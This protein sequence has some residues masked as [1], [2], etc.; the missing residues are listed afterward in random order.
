M[1]R[2]E[3]LRMLGLA[4]LSAGALPVILRS[5]DP[6]V[7]DARKASGILGTIAVDRSLQALVGQSYG[8]LVGAVGLHFRDTPYIAGTLEGDRE[9]CRVVLSGVDCVTFFE[10]TIAI[11]NLLETGSEL[12]L[13]VLADVVTKTRYRN[14]VVDGYT[15][16]LHYFVD[17]V[18]DNAMRGRVIDV[19]SELDGATKDKRTID[20]MSTHRSAYAA[21]KTDDAALGRIREIETTL[22]G[23]ER[24]YLPKSKISESAPGIET[25]DIIGITTS[26]QGL[27]V[28]HTGLAYRDDNDVVR[29]LHASTSKK[30]V[31]LDASIAS[32][33][34]GNRKQTGIIVA[35]PLP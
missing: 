1:N 4:T 3:T 34:S 13:A 15:S 2:R 10:S 8:K 11:A 27:D 25:G 17:W 33:I 26:I 32:Y 24:W 7:L 30:K 21:L 5:G 14:G 28:S 22:N 6:A 19:T 20:F 31:V 12:S 9:V 23:Q 35:R 18:A 29:L 16:R